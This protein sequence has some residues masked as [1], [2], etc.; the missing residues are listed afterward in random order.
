[1]SVYSL[2]HFFNWVFALLL[3]LYYFVKRSLSHTLVVSSFCFAFRALRSRLKS[4]SIA[5]STFYRRSMDHRYDI[6]FVS[7]LPFRRRT[8]YE[9][10]NNTIVSCVFAV[11]V[12]ASTSQSRSVR[13][14]RTSELPVL[15]FLHSLVSGATYACLALQQEEIAIPSCRFYKRNL[16]GRSL[17]YNNGIT[18]SINELV[19]ERIDDIQWVSEVFEHF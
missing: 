8:V 14:T 1:M 13:R 18:R 12:R 3:R 10:R 19:N 17:R 2:G 6:T 9:N 4:N 15:N 7:V 11:R 5:T 16:T